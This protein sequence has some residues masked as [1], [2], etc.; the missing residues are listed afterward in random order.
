MTQE[1]IGYPEGGPLRTYYPIIDNVAEV[2][3]LQP[4]H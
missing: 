1:T 3:G 4:D 2:K